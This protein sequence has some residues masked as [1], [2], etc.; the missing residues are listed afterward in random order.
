[1]EELGELTDIFEYYGA[2]SNSNIQQDT[3]AFNS[4]SS[5]TC[6]DW[7]ALHEACDNNQ[8]D[9]CRNLIEGEGIALLSVED[10]EQR[11]PIFLAVSNRNK[12]ICEILIEAGADIFRRNKEGS[13][14][15]HIAVKANDYDLC[16]ML[17]TYG[18][19]VNATNRIGQS[20][21]FLVDFDSQRN[22][23]F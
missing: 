22:I 21:I 12:E 16:E 8:I 6:H 19:D 3:T 4:S 14:L 7:T 20:P 1:M 17:L 23:I 2:V 11:T 13:T 15:L 18:V 10:H 5:K 9:C